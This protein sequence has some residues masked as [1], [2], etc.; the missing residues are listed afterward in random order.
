MKKPNK[1]NNWKTTI[2]MFGI[3]AVLIVTI[4]SAYSSILTQAINQ[5]QAQ[6]LNATEQ[7]TYVTDIN[8]HFKTA[9][10]SVILFTYCW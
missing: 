9:C 7:K 1:I 3:T 6:T 8:V 2:A 4:I 10:I 5:A